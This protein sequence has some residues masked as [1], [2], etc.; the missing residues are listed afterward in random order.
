[1]AFV[2]GTL[3]DF[4]LAALAAYA[5]EIVFTPSGPGVNDTTLFATRP[6]SVTPAANGSFAVNLAPTEDI[7]PDR[8][9]AIS[10][11][12]LDSSGG[13]IG[14]DFPDWQLRVPSAGGK[15]NDLLNV[16]ANPGQVWVSETPPT[17][18]SP[19]TWWLNPTT[20]DLNEWS[21]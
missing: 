18:P 7:R 5:P 15:V 13:Y 1:M 19:G 10:M 20:G 12:W 4:G 9:Y 21:N 14:V 3:T 16:P 17:N 2:T 11:R 8:W 6:I